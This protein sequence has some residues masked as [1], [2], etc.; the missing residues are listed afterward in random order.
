[1]GFSQGAIL[2]YAAALSFPEKVRQVVA[3]SGY[4]HEDLLKKGYTENDF[5]HLRFF[6][7][8]GM[9]DEVVPVDW[10][11]KTQPFL[12]QLNIDST[13]KEFPVG[14]GVTPENFKAVLD[15]LKQ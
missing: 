14:H 12:Q 1:M 4:I 8:H 5:S 2:S 9:I 10:D 15:W 3:M 11:R 6:S 13:Y 7:S